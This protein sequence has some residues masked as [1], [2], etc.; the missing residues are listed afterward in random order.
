MYVLIYVFIYV[1]MYWIMVRGILKVYIFDVIKC[2]I[3]VYLLL[4][5]MDNSDKIRK[6][7]LD[8]FSVEISF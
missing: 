6:K 3:C 2:T 8:E 1:F 4:K 7:K 5:K